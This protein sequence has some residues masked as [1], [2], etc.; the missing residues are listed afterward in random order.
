VAAYFPHHE[1]TIHVRAC[2]EGN[3]KAAAYWDMHTK[4]GVVMVDD[5][6]EDFNSFDT[7]WR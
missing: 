2:F 1:D 4:S 6:I 3:G 7:P 5:E